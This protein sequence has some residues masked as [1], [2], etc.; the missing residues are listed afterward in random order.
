M[1]ARCSGATKAFSKGFETPPSLCAVRGNP[2]QILKISHFAKEQLSADA[3]KSNFDDWV[4]QARPTKNDRFAVR[5]IE[6]AGAGQWRHALDDGEDAM[7]LSPGGLVRP[8]QLLA[9][10][11][12]QSV[13]PPRLLVST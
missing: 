6:G 7:L 1:N 12:A 2:R 10:S 3:A 9:A 13:R 4:Q 5:S 8:D 11:M